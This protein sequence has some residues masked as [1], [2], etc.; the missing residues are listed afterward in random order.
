MPATDLRVTF[1]DNSNV[2]TPYYYEGEKLYRR[3]HI[4]GLSVYSAA[5]LPDG[6]IVLWIN[7]SVWNKVGIL[8]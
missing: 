2:K 1:T 6:I 3:A 4:K 8:T 5:M 7:P